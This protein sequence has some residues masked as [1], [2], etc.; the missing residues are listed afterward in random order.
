M[1]DEYSELIEERGFAESAELLAS[2]CR[3]KDATIITLRS[4][5]MRAKDTIKALHGD[6]A[7]DIYDQHSPEMKQINHALGEGT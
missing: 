4:A 7:W 6:I 5:L 2:S 1:K 3:A